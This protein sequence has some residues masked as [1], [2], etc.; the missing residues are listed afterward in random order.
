MA[1]YVYD[2]LQDSVTADY[3]DGLHSG[4]IRGKRISLGG[5]VAGWAAANRRFVLNADP[6]LDLGEAAALTP[7]L[8]SSI[9]VPLCHD[10]SVAA[11]L[12]LY[13]TATEAFTDDQARLLTLLA[14]SLAS[15]LAAVPKADA[16]AQPAA[17]QRRPAAGE[18]MRLV[19]R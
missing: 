5:G 15:S 11:V 12:S 19:R 18:M 17:E 8:R 4:A 2:K 3:T 16:W 1:L 9:T 7:A 6:A 14:P 10:G 13:S